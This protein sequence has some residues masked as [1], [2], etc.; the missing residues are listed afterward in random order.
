MFWI[1]LSSYGFTLGFF[2][3]I[4]YFKLAKKLNFK[5]FNCQICLSFWYGFFISLLKGYQLID[6]ILIAFL[7]IVFTKILDNFAPNTNNK[8]SEIEVEL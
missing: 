8:L 7:S 3:L 6:C 4:R 2:E 5:P 1:A